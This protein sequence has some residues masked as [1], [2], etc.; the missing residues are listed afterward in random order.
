M[1]SGNIGSPQIPSTQIQ[2]IASFF[3]KVSLQVSLLVS[4]A[5]PALKM[6]PLRKASGIR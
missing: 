1:E 6:A 5:V 2:R 3:L 4:A